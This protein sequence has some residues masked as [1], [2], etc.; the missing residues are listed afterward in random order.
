MTGARKET[1][2]III[3]WLHST[4]SRTAECVTCAK[5]RNVATTLASLLF[6]ILIIRAQGSFALRPVVH[7]PFVFTSEPNDRNFIRDI[8]AAM[9]IFFRVFGHLSHANSQ[10]RKLFAH[11]K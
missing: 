10:K 8:C 6:A 1:I 11:S 9:S 3:H 2:I 4:P 5:V 7:R